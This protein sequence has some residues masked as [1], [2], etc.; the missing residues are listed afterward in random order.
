MAEASWVAGKWATFERCLGGTIEPFSGDFNVNLGQALLALH[1][2][3]YDQFTAVVRRLRAG[4]ARG[5]SGPNTASLQACHE[6]LLRLHV[7][8]EVEAISGVLPTPM[9][10]KTVLDTLDRRLTILGPFLQDKQ[11]ILGVRRAT[12]KLSKSVHF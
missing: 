3:E 2:E 6:N 10:H 5:L 9:D 1:K 8:S 7:L 12:M 11:Y 4:I